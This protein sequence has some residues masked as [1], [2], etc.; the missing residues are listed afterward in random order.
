MNSGLGEEDDE[1]NDASPEEVVENVPD[2]SQRPQIIRMAP[3][4]PQY[5]E[6]SVYNEVI[7]DGDFVYFAILADAEPINHNETY[8]VEMIE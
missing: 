5:F 4:R 8:N 6:V 2:V 7:K 1:S 3:T